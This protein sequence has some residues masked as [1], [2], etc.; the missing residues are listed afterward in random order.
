M[1]MLRYAI[2]KL[3]RCAKYLSLAYSVFLL[4]FD[5]ICSLINASFYLQTGLLHQNHDK[6][7]IYF[8]YVVDLFNNVFPRAMIVQ[9]TD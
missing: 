4:Y 2:T 5:L 3:F 6:H 1:L 8:L 9:M 7:H